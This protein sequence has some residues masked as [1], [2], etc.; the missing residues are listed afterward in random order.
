MDSGPMILIELGECSVDL[1]SACLYSLG[2]G[3][4]DL[5]VGQYAASE[6]IQELLFVC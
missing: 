2:M 4:T 6:V 1:L 5:T 3:P